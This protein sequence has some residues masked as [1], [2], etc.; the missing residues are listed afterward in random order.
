MNI[1][2]YADSTIEILSKNIFKEKEEIINKKEID[3]N[4]FCSIEK[5]VVFMQKGNLIEENLIKHNCANSFFLAEAINNDIKT[6][7]QENKTKI[8]YSLLFAMPIFLGLESL[9]LFF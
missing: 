1:S 5:K 7:E 2:V 9:T 3:S 4:L 6:E 8:L